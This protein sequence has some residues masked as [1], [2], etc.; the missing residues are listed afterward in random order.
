MTLVTDDYDCR[1][2]RLPIVPADILR[3]FHV[4]EVSDTRFSGCARLLQSLWRERRD[5]EIGRHRSSN[6][7]S[8]KLGSRISSTAGRAGFAFLAPDIAKIVRREVAYREIGA[9]IEERRLWENLLSSQGLTFNLFARSCADRAYANRL[10]MALFPDFIREVHNVIFE[11]SPGR[12]DTRYLGDYTA[13]DLFVT[14]RA[15]D[16]SPVFVAVEVKYAESMGQRG[17]TTNPRYRELTRAYALHLDPESPQLLAEPLAQL[18]AEHL[19][20]DTIRDQLGEVG[21]GVFVTIA[22]ANNR[23]AWNAIELYRRSLTN[24]PSRT[25]FLALS[26]E[27]VVDK[28]RQS[29]DVRLADSLHER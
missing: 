26:L 7:K 14:G 11:H 6:G 27:A 12:G 28:I 25:P 23:E 22:P 5:L 13:F 16:G 21:R 9:L 19:L 20:A 17:R 24:L 29:D 18:T 3:R 10:F 1:P 4:D 15:P 2:V 8:R